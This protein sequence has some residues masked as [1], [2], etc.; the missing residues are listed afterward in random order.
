M[1]YNSL[2]NLWKKMQKASSYGYTYGDLSEEQF[3]EWIKEQI[4]ERVP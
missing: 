2:Y 4:I 3:K 1:K